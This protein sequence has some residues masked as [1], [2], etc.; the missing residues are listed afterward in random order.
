MASNTSQTREFSVMHDMWE[1]T[2][3]RVL[4]LGSWDMG[5]FTRLL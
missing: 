3:P 1:E 4:L 5:L 2:G